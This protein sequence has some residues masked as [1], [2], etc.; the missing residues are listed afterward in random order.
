ME[1]TSTQFNG[2]NINVE[3]YQEW[4]IAFFNTG[5][6]ALEDK[7]IVLVNGKPTKTSQG[8]LTFGDLKNDFS[9]LQSLAAQNGHKIRVSFGADRMFILDDYKKALMPGEN[10]ALSE[11]GRQKEKSTY[12]MPAVT[13][14]SVIEISAESGQN[15]V[16]SLDNAWAAN[17]E[18]LNRRIES[19]FGVIQDSSTQVAMW[20]ALNSLLESSTAYIKAANDLEVQ[21]TNDQIVID[22]A[23]V[24]TFLTTLE[25]YDKVSRQPILTAQEAPKKLEPPKEDDMDFTILPEAQDKPDKA[26]PEMPEFAQSFDDFI[27]Q[28]IT[29]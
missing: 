3:T 2:Q 15:K 28:N 10:T 21:Y 5:T 19:M 23:V 6:E 9:L 20:A 1:A 7:D 12:I 8:F 25:Q 27:G 22:R 14:D 16:Y 17:P 26:K 18:E 29:K 24:T 4:G 13:I 11:M